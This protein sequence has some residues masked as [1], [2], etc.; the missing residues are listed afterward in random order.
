MRSAPCVLALLLS[1]PLF[2]QAGER[3]SALDLRLPDGP[4]FADGSASPYRGDPPGAYYGDT[5]GVPPDPA[6]TTVSRCPTAPDGTPRSVT[7]SFTTGIG[8]SSRGGNSHYNGTSV[9]YCKDGY[10]DEGNSRSVEMS[11]HLQQY[12]GPGHSGYYGGGSSG[13]PPP[14][15]MRSRSGPPRR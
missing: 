3:T 7:G 1:T 15:P 9:N 12:D 2:A 10:D 13:G 8:W 6:D 14:A 4:M 11:I 5:T